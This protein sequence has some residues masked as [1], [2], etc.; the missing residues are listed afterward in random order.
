M[1]TN[2]A[3]TLNGATT[4]STSSKKCVDLFFIAGASRTMSEEQITTM[5]FQAF[6]EDML[7]ALTI[8]FWARDVRGGAGERRF[9]RIIWNA[10]N[11]PDIRNSW[12]SFL[13]TDIAR[14]IPEFGRWDDIWKIDNFQPVMSNIMA[15]ELSKIDNDSYRSMYSLLPKWMPR[16]GKIFEMVRKRMKLTPKELRKL[17][18][19]HS[20]TPEQLM[21]TNNFNFI[22][23]KSV[24]SVAFARYK[25]AFLKHD[26]TRFN[27]FLEDVENG[28]SKVNASAVFPHDIIKGLDDAT[29]ATQA[30]WDALPDYMANCNSKIL[31]LCDVSG[32]MSIHV[33]G[34]TTAMDICIALGMYISE[35]NEGIFKDAFITFSENPQINYVRGDNLYQRYRSLHSAHWGYNTNIKKVF[36][37]LL[38][39]AE[40]NNISP[41]D[42]PDTILIMSD[43][44]FDKASEDAFGYTNFEVIA[45]KYNQSG[46]KM[47]QIVFWNLNGRIGN[48][49]V[50]A[51][52]ENFALISGFSPAILQSVL[53][54]DTDSFSPEAIMNKTLSNPRYDSIRQSFSHFM[55]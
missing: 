31:P 3:L 2:D 1:Q 16:K 22:D 52:K 46:Y 27:M 21:C 19:K 5:W 33:S 30:Q 6:N 34:N 35:R 7:T 49:P 18:V 47:P 41:N 53:S 11:E 43:M 25:R 54:M 17:I 9:F 20:N 14:L 40:N 29:D 42:M 24:P 37:T 10:L 13:H 55:D 23:Y 51:N 45:E 39:K 38:D 48:V 36:S 15:I 32:S 4:N 50:T 12:S 8:L 26:E 28:K 44:E